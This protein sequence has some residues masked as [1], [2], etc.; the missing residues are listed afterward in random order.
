[1]KCLTKFENTKGLFT[2]SDVHRTTVKFRMVGHNAT[3]DTVDASQSGYTRTTVERRYFKK[4]FGVDHGM[5]HVARFVDFAAV[6][7]DHRQE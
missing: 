1:M 5:D 7:W 4:A 6:F 2:R 3:S